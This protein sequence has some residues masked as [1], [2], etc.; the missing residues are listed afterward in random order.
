MLFDA[1]GRCITHGPS[2]YK[3]PSV[4]D[5]PL[6]FRVHLLEHA[7]EPG[8]IGG[9]KAVGEPPLMHGIAAITALRHAISAFHSGGTVVSLALPATPEAILRAVMGV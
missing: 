2:T 1:Q 8:V 5:V 3:I 6:D 4:G 7:V 9:S